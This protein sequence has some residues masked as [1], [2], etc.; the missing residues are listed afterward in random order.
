MVIEWLSMP[1]NSCLSWSISSANPDLR[2]SHM[3][4]EGSSDSA[5]NIR[6][7]NRACRWVS[8][9]LTERFWRSSSL[10]YQRRVEDLGQRETPRGDVAA[11]TGLPTR[12]G[13]AAVTH[14][15]WESRTL[16]AWQSSAR[17]SLARP[18]PSVTRASCR[19][20]HR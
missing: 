3:A 18:S 11:Q 13:R 7:A 2:P 15:S 19:L 1:V 8:S 4:C 14:T 5:C 17:T 10:H 20:C 6:A 12:G 16:T 9:D